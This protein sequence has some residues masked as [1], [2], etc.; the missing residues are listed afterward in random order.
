MEIRVEQDNIKAH[1][2]TQNPQAQEMLDRHLPR[3]REA[4][5]QQGLRLD[6]VEITVADKNDNRQMFQNHHDQQQL[7][8]SKTNH[9]QVPITA[10]KSEEEPEEGLE[11]Q[12]SLN[13]LA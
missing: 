7:D 4:L 3:L 2:T 5:E 1:I 10:L 6:Q 13:V 12:Q 11:P 9:R 8:R